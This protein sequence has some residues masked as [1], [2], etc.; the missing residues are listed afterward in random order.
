M[1]FDKEGEYIETIEM[2]W[3]EAKKYCRKN[4]YVYQTV[5]KQF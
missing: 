1:F 5:T 3:H 2:S 4:D